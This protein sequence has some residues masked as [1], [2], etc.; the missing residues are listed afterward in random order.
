[1][2]GKPRQ[3]ET[4]AQ[5]YDAAIKILMR[6]AHSVHEMKKALARR[7]EDD[8]IV[9]GVVE[10]LKRENLLDDARYAK[11][12]T[13]LHTES[14]KQGE[15]RIARDLRARGIPDRHIETA[16][17]DAAAGSDPASIIRQRI[18]R[19]LRLYRG[20]IDERKLASLYRS[21]IGA[22]FP[23]DL[24]RKELHRITH[25]EI[26]EVEPSDESA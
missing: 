8:K 15:F 9:R 11:Q 22:G 23:S 24:I 10:R 4:D 21:L 14:R 18:E 5:V 12:F 6:R 16:I 3:L 7:C 20:E 19:K 13:R 2:F 25:E 1:M 17:K 26:P